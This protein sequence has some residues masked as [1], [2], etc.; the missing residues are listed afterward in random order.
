MHVVDLVGIA[1]VAVW[2]LGGLVIAREARPRP[3][4]VKLMAVLA[5]ALGPL[6][7][8]C[9]LGIRYVGQAAAQGRLLSAQRGPRPMPE[10]WPPP[11]GLR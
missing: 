1:Y 4:I 11:P 5:I 3:G 7:M 9:Y 8:L 6:G 2:I 10:D